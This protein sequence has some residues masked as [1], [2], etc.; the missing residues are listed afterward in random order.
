MDGKLVGIDTAI[1]SR[2]GG[3][4]GIGF[5]IPSNMVIQIEQQL[6]QHGK[7]TRGWFGVIMKDKDPAAPRSG[8]EV[9]GVMPDGPAARAG[10]TSGD[11]I[12]RF[13]GVPVS[14]AAHL[15][16]LVALSGPTHV[17]VEVK[18]GG[19]QILHEVSLVEP[20]AGAER[21]HAHADADL[22]AQ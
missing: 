2:S 15:R 11:V 1:V 6:V 12:V 20:P 17:S 4:Q 16:N 5:A 9:S 7:V 13:A 18:H 8:V 21:K 3:Y 10:I 14:D 19:K 22:S